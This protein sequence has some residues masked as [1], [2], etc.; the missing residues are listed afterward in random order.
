MLA[1]LWCCVDKFYAVPDWN[2][3]IRR[4]PHENPKVLVF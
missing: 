4:V 3:K 2:V 1:N